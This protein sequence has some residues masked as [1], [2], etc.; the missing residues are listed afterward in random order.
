MSNIDYLS[1]F[2]KARFYFDDKLTIYKIFKIFKIS[3]LNKFQFV[4]NVANTALQ[5]T[6][7]W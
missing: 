4:A 2:I 1:I 6:A 7:K 3:I 5:I